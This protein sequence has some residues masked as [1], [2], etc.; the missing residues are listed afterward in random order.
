MPYKK[1][2]P[3]A[4]R[5]GT[6][7]KGSVSRRLQIHEN[8]YEDLKSARK[9]MAAYRAGQ[10]KRYG[11]D[12]NK[13]TGKYTLGKEGRPAV[14]AASGAVYGFK[15]DNARPVSRL[16]ATR[17]KRILDSIADM[18]YPVIKDHQLLNTTQV[19]WSSGT[20]AVV[21]YA[22]GYTTAE[23][24][25]MMTQSASASNIS[26]A[27]MVVPAV[28]SETNQRLDIYDKT[29]KFNYKNTCSHT[30]YLE[31]VPFECLG[32]HSFSVIQSWAYALTADNM[33]QNAAT[34]G[35][36][37]TQTD[38]GNRPDMRMP[39]LNCRWK[40]VPSGIHKIA[41]E[42]G[43]ETSYTYVT[44]GGRYDQAKFN[45]LAGGAGSTTDVAYLPKF[46]TRMLLFARAEMVADALDADVTYGSGHL[47]VNAELWRSWS[48]VPYVKPYQASFVQQWGTVVEANELDMN[49]YQANNDPY[50]EQV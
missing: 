11:I 45:V 18:K 48:A 23:I 12:R 14:D 20:Q 27:A 43:Q 10:D 21:E 16:M 28:A 39:D 30:L 37:Q 40:L 4:K 36:E 7:K 31:F 35:T 46:T 50:E 47:A 19:D 25:N 42:P 24:Q 5:S 6:K 13:L 2:V 1:S 49:Q 9:Y 44:R 38:I 34:F 15:Y 33:V 26:T 8:V 17:K 3:N 32:Y 22:L 41:L 29:V